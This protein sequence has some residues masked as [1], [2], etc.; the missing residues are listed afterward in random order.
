MPAAAFQAPCLPGG[1][2]GARRPARP[3]LPAPFPACALPLPAPLPCLRRHVCASTSQ[4]FGVGA[5]SGQAWTR[6]LARPMPAGLCLRGMPRRKGHASAPRFTSACRQTQAMAALEALL[7]L[8]GVSEAVKAG[9]PVHAVS[10]P[11]YPV[12]RRLASDGDAPHI[13]MALNG[14]SREPGSSCGA[15]PGGPD[16]ASAQ[17]AL[18][19]GIV[20][21][22]G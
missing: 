18:R 14:R 1:N 5:R 9:S 11:V 3:S 4:A 17:A 20:Q 15:W 13:A 21:R 16:A 2:A 10:S 22:Q 8:A 19:Q 12:M 7:E 6:C